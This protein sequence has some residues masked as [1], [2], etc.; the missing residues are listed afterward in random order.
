M[1]E[2]LDGMSAYLAVPNLTSANLEILSNLMETM[3]QALEE[4]NDVSKWVSADEEFH[5]FFYN[6][7]NNLILLNSIQKIRTQIHWVRYTIT[8]V[9]VNRVVSTK[10]H[11]AIFKA[12]KGRDAEQAR[13]EAQR[14][15]NRVRAEV[16][17]VLM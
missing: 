13:I 8:P 11:R 5:Y 1:A 2:A 14:H 4:N 12:L 17:K 10:E 9:A 3:E 15:M 16:L 6:I 7:S